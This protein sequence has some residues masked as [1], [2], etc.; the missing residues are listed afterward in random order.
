LLIHFGQIKFGWEVIERKATGE[1]IKVV[2]FQPKE[3]I[4][5]DELVRVVE[6]SL[7]RI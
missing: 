4:C 6:E 3:S 1:K 2:Q 7:K 5:E